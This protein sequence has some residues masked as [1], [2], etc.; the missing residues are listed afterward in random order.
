MNNT[1]QIRICSIDKTLLD[2]YLSFLQTLFKK[3]NI[4]YTST[5]LPVKTK[6]ITLLKS[7]HVHKKA[8]EQFEV[9]RFTKLFTV[10]DFKTT[11][12]L[13]FIFLNKPKFIKIKLKK[14]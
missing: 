2:I 12:Y 14:M 5:N 9:K 8:R 3:L 11:K 6:K 10:R 1:I 13:I 7:P 4:V